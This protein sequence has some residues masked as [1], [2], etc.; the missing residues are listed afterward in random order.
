M[1]ATSEDD[2]ARIERYGKYYGLM[3]K[4]FEKKCIIKKALSIYYYET[5]RIAGNF[6]DH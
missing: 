6:G 4:P 5:H 3:A 2:H 1:I